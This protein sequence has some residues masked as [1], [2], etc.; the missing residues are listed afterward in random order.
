MI[1]VAH[2][3]EGRAAPRAQATAGTNRCSRQAFV[4]LALLHVAMSALADDPAGEVE[5]LTA[6]AQRVWKLPSLQPGRDA[7]MSTTP[8]R[9][10]T[11]STP[12]FIHR[13]Q[14][15]RLGEKANELQAFCGQQGG[16]WHYLGVDEGRKTPG[17]QLPAH[18]ALAE[19][20]RSAPATE[21]GMRHIVGTGEQSA[22]GDVLK[23]TVRELMKRPDS[24]VA[25]AFEHAMRQKWLGRFECRGTAS[26]WA[27]AISYANAASRSDRKGFVYRDVTLKVELAEIK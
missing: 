12:A 8:L 3:D 11:Y 9:V 16:Q 20:V 19:A 15:E 18:P 26:P 4:A 24:L 22:A 25:V 10:S 6:Y 13:G 21:A 23:A 17:N 1:A 7:V 2:C 27:A 14:L 5:T